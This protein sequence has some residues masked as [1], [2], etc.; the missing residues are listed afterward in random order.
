MNYNTNEIKEDEQ[1][2]KDNRADLAGSHSKGHSRLDDLGNSHSL[3]SDQIIYESIMRVL[4]RN[5]DIDDSQI[6]V[7]VRDGLV[8][9]SGSIDS[10]ANKM[11][12]KE[13]ISSVPGV[14]NIINDIQVERSGISP[15][16]T[17]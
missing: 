5:S 11:M 16:P 8:S 14:K 2:A 7:Q 4:R 17:I 12:I 1:M 13:S 10:H 3:S 15:E 6:Q 9:L